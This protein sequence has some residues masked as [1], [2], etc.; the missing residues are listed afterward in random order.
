MSKKAWNNIKNSKRF[1]VRTYRKLGSML[2]FSATL[3]VCLGLG[4]YHV[5]FNLPERDFYATFGEVPPVKLTA[6]EEPNYSSVPLL[7][8]D[9]H[10]DSEK[11]VIPK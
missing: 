6:M 2:L 4:I 7:A 3:N 5:Y 10:Y 1:Y 8:D 9:I 11:R